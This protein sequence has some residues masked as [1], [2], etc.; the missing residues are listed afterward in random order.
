[1]IDNYEAIF[2]AGAEERLGRACKQF[3]VEQ[4]IT[5]TF[6][7]VKGQ[8]TAVEKLGEVGYAAHSDA[9]HLPGRGL[10]ARCWW[11][12]PGTA[13]LLPGLWSGDIWRVRENG[14]A[15][16]MYWPLSPWQPSDLRLGTQYRRRPVRTVFV[17]AEGGSRPVVIFIDE[18]DAVAKARGQEDDEVLI[19]LL[20]CMDGCGTRIRLCWGATNRPEILDLALLGAPPLWTGGI[21]VACRDRRWRT[22]CGCTGE[23]QL[24]HSG[25]SGVAQP[26]RE[27]E[28]DAWWPETAEAVIRETRREATAQARREL[29]NRSM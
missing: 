11:V 21:P 26:K 23:K 16:A 12:C 19:A 6:N 4:D 24:R 25:P 2:E 10:A 5:E 29:A 27:V 8:E 18:L 7:D 1:M 20:A 28:L 15:A 14:P 17:G 3:K 13:D 9:Y 22:F